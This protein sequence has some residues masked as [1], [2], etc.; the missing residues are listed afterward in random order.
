LGPDG[1]CFRIGGKEI[2]WTNHAHLVS[3]W[4]AWSHMESLWSP[5]RSSMRMAARSDRGRPRRI[6]GEEARSGP[7]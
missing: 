6:P 2:A 4:S 5:A 7:R 3:S 1:A